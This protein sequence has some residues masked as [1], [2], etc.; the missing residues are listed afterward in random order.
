MCSNSD[1]IP[2]KMTAINFVESAAETIA[3]VGVTDT[4]TATGQVT[5]AGEWF[6][7]F[8]SAPFRTKSIDVMHCTLMIK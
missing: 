6:Y 8:H 5:G 7:I 4:T 1:D 3:T 2:G